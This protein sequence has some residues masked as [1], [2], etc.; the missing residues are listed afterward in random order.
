MT[1]CKITALLIFFAIA[2]VIAAAALDTEEY[3]D[4][5][6]QNPNHGKYLHVLDEYIESEKNIDAIISTL[7]EISLNHTTAPYQ[8]EIYALLAYYEEITGRLQ[9]AQK[10]YEIAGMLAQ[11]SQD[12]SPLID[13][14]RLLI[15]TGKYKRAQTQAQAYINVAK[16]NTFKRYAR[17]LLCTAFY[18]G[19]EYEKAKTVFVTLTSSAEEMKKFGPKELYLLILAAK[20]TGKYAEAENLESILLEQYPESP[21]LLMIQKKI[22][23]QLEASPLHLLALAEPEE[24]NEEGNEKADGAVRV[25]TGLFSRKENA[26]ALQK[27]LAAKGFQTVIKEIKRGG[28]TLFRVL[29]EPISLQDSQ[30]YI[31]RLKEYG[32]EGFLVFDASS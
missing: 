3:K 18:A 21:E 19:G 2:P 29:S 31:I 20:G 22:I 16:N 9:D 30:Q 7:R 17:V 28:E 14:I 27:S 4:W 8:P 24:G 25:Q 6:H 5:L 12:R 15:E 13:S 10:H 11:E 1:R 32:Y 23:V 26:I